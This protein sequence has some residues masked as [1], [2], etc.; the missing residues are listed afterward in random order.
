MRPLLPTVLILLT[1][2]SAAAQNNIPLPQGEPP[3]LPDLEP[4]PPGPGSGPRLPRVQL[5]PIAPAIP[6]KTTPAPRVKMNPGSGDGESSVHGGQFRVYGKVKEQRTV[7]LEEAEA[8]RRMLTAALGMDPVF[9]FPVV[10]QIRETSA[11]RPGQPAVWSAI[12]QTD[13]GFR[14]EINLVPK[15]NAVDGPLLRQ[16][17]VRCLLAE[18]LLRPHAASDLSGRDTPP[19]DWLL[20]GV[21]ELLD[22]QALGRPSDAFSTVFRLGRVLSIDDIFAA[23]PRFMDSV[24]SMIYRSSC[25]GL[26]LML[27]EQKNAGQGVKELFKILALMSG[28]DATAIARACPDLNLSGNSLGKW[29][30]LQLAT[31]AQP[32][33]DEL[34]S[35]HETEEQLS[36]ALRMELPPEPTVAAKPRKGL[37]KL[38]GKKKSGTPET[39]QQPAAV[40]QTCSLEEYSRVLPRKDRAAILGRVNLALTQMA[41]RAHPLYRPLIG[42]YQALIKALSDGKKEKEAAATLASLAGLRRTLQRDLQKSEDYLDWYE[43]TQ[44]DGIS[45]AF[46]GYLRTVE[47]LTRPAAPR[48]DPL[49]RYL[50][51]MESEYQPE[52]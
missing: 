13:D 52:E 10:M 51:L 36:R 33:M 19:P 41:L 49:C 7:L 47:A 26:L 40:T 8:T 34:L 12:S 32:G 28:D 31:M 1:A 20:H 25:C 44:T 14:M 18:M 17:L 2:L 27:M 29:W 35:P 48:R 11:I 42:Q 15:N 37:A 24:S 39:E 6:G 5:V 21:L 4:E 50:N 45:S 22:Y 16:E 9:T 30:S 38:F 43:A 46:D 3:P 23:D